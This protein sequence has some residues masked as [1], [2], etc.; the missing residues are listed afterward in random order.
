[1]SREFVAA[2]A[3]Q[4]EELCGW[5]LLDLVAILID[6]I[7]LGQQV[8]MVALGI[9]TTGKKHV[10]VLWRGATENTTMVKDSLQD[11]VARGLGTERR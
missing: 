3:A 11:L 4:L 8:L 10:L 1:M 9:E 7:H 5:K 2:S 6:R